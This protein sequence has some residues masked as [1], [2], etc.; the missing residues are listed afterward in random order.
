MVWSALHACLLN[1]EDPLR[2]DETN[3]EFNLINNEEE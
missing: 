2:R 1:Q 3:C